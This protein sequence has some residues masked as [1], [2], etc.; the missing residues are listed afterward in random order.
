MR[1]RSLIEVR[2]TITGIIGRR[3]SPRRVEHLDVAILRDPVHFFLLSENLTCAC[4][5]QCARLMQK[6]KLLAISRMSL[7]ANFG[8][9][10]SANVTGGALPEPWSS[11]P[12]RDRLTRTLPGLS[13]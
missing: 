2:K 4:D 8:A 13:K 9:L 5:T 12:S 7:L 1:M 6:T 11:A 3:A 10:W